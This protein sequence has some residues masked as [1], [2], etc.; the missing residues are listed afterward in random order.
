[1]DVGM[2]KRLWDGKGTLRLSFTDVFHT[3]RWSSYTT[4]G[5]LSIDA[6]GRWEGQQLKANFTYRFGNNSVQNARRRATAAD[7]ESK[8]AGDGGGGGGRN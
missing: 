5:A 2:T 4:L 8:R 3:A 6:Q 7:E 1:M